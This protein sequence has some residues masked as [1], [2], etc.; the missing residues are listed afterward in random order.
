MGFKQFCTIIIASL[1]TCLHSYAQYDPDK[2]N[3]KVVAIYEEALSFAHM[4]NY[5]KA[6]TQLEGAVAKDPRFLDAWLSIAGIHGEMKHY[7]EAIDG[8]EKAKAIDSN[9]FRDYNLPYSINLAGQGNFQKAITAVDDFLRIPNLNEKSKMVAQFRKKSYQFAIDYAQ[10]R[11]LGGYRFEPSNLGDSINSKDSEYYPTIT[12]DGKELIFT[13]RMNGINED[14]FGASRNNNGWHKALPLSGNINTQSNEGAQ[15]ISQDGQWLI[16][17]GCNFPG[18]A[19]SCDLYI[20]YLTSSGWSEPESLGPRINT[21]AW[22]SAPSLSPDKKELYFASNRAGGFGGSD[23]YVSRLLPNGRWGEPENLGA[24]INTPGEESCPFIHADNQ[25]LY[26]TSNGHLGYGG[27][28]L[29]ISKKQ[30]KGG[31]SRAVNLG[32]PINTIENEGS[33]VVSADGKTAWYASDRS[34]S[35]GGLDIYTFELRSDVRPAR[36]LWVK[37]KVYDIKTNRGLPSS[38]ELTDLASQEVLSK[39]QTDETGHYLVTLPVGKDYAFNVNR[40]GYLFFSENFSLSNNTDSVFNIDIPLQPLE[41][42]ASMV[43][44]NVFFDVNK[45]DLKPES[46]S[47]LDKLV[48]LLRDNPTIRIQLSGHTDNVG[49]AEDNLVLSNNRAQ[50]VV[51]YLVAHGIEQQRLSFKGYGATQP[52]ADNT[53]EEGRA[54]NR[55]TELKVISQ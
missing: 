37:G 50:A 41:A 48:V 43:L 27:D 12:I 47:E 14:F 15:N 16:F 49:K 20:S 2:V 46:T 35:K 54:K 33:L 4:G 19:G 25:T 6:L 28:D 39:V 51:K 31:W 40:K 1:A 30:P 13:R 8:Y 44:R 7:K 53:T 42:N 26:F 10:Q 3:R 17:T 36:T 22:E 55:R 52:V 34:D 11:P 32:Y 5:S 29:F 24:E 23:L 21:E 38:V 9:Y 18:G 45:F